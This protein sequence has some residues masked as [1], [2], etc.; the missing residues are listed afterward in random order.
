M[1]D[2]VIRTCPQVLEKQ[3]AIYSVARVMRRCQPVEVVREWLEKIKASP[4]EFNHQAY[5]EMLFLY[6]WYYQDS[7][8]LDHIMKFLS[9]R[10]D[11]NVLLGL[12][13]SAS[14]L[15]SEL[16]DR[17][18]AR[19]ILCRLVSHHDKSIQHAVVDVFRCNR[20]HFQLNVD[21]R[22][23]IQA[24]CSNRLVLL[25]AATDL[26]ELLIDYTGIEPE[27]VSKV[28]RE[29]IRTGGSDIGN[30]R[31][32]LAL[33]AEPLTNIALT[34]HRHPEYREIGLQMFEEL[35]SL[36]IRETRAAL[37]ILDRKPMKTVTTSSR[38][39]RRRKRL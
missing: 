35:I 25:E 17:T 27:F 18:M 15:W 19:E 31:T 4:S 9:E 12:A 14:H 10:D 37:D 3:F 30:I 11:E 28:C 24:V 16:K 39:R 29:L 36:N 38:P 22:E 34:L 1:Y 20:E 5:G 21:I 8:S 13:Y 32:S 33:L 6:H 2:A 23:V 26:V 7:W